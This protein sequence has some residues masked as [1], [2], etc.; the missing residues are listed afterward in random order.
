MLEQT[1]EG[2][3]GPIYDLDWY[4][5]GLLLSASGDCTVRIW[6][7]SMTSSSQAPAAAAAPMTSAIAVLLHPAYV[8]A[9]RFHPNASEIVATVIAQLHLI[10]IKLQQ[11][12]ATVWYIISKL[13]G[14]LVLRL[15]EETHTWRLWVQI[16]VQF[17]G[18]TFFLF[19]CCENCNVCLK[20]LNK[21][22]RGW[23][24]SIKK[25]GYNYNN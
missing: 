12:N 8:Y 5:D 18:W 17:I 3:K 11:G 24:W 21:W 7:L 25:Q 16:L 23:V 4:R 22:K 15:W 2:H 10:V 14:S 9:A 20:R 13:E 1:L 6:S 19:I